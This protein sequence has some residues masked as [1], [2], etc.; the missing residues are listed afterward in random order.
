MTT[1][2]SRDAT[3]VHNPATGE[4]VSTVA[5]LSDDEVAGRAK[6]ARAAQPAWHQ[7][8]YRERAKVLR[9][10]Q[11]WLTDNI[12]R[13]F[14]TLIGETGKTYEDAQIEITACAQALGF[15]AKH[16]PKYLADERVPGGSPLLFGRK[17]IV[18]YE[19]VGL[20]GVIGPWN[21]PL[22]NTFCDAIPALIAGNAVLLKPS[23]TTPLTSFL[24]GEMMRAAGMPSDVMPVV[25][26]SGSAVVDA[27]DYV[28]LTGST[29]T[30]TKVMEQAAKTLTPVSL[31]LGG[32]DPMIVLADADLE[33]AANGAVYYSML[34]AG[35][36]CISV[37]RVYVES[38]AYDEFV[39]KVLKK[40]AALR[41]GAP[42]GPG[43]VEIGAMTSA[44]QI[45]IIDTQV[46][47]AVAKGAKVLTG[48]RRGDGPGQFYEPT[49]L[50]DVDHTM[51]CMTEE[52]FGPVLPIM[53]VRDADEAIMLAND[54]NFGLQSS[55]WT[56][57][58]A[59]GRKLAQQVQAGVCCVNDAML[60]YMAFRAPMAGWK[61]S[62]V[63]GR[64]GAAGIRKYCL[65][66]TVTVNRF[67]LHRDMHMF[68]YSPKMSR[69]ST[70][71]VRWFY[72]RGRR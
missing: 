59:R 26:G 29:E 48:G 5:R 40:V 22:A 38:P 46:E 62:G 65:T 64:H 68:P 11:R 3:A 24:A 42:D 28:M 18:R 15:W 2:T 4:P 49:V 23:S 45:N 13:F 35:Q 50:V 20:V 19:P 34:N 53:R 44:E 41:V 12:D 1:Q 27:V 8:G 67:P 25:T 54:C 31:E 71:F 14:E 58:R 33:R 43:S 66:Q 9:R 39:R 16:G 36:V 60:N 10:A 37:E 21:Y 70:R 51:R 69:A 57:S 63:G 61:A 7:L 72:G 47:D 17:V 52:T 6:A 32:K 56:G 30:G 55:I